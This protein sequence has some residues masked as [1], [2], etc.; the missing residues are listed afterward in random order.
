MDPE[1]EWHKL[2]VLEQLSDYGKDQFKEMPQEN[3]ES[4]VYDAMMSDFFKG[5]F[6]TNDA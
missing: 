5:I 4:L 3:Q 2:L 1:Y 6:P